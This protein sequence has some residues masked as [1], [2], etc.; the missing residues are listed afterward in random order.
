[1]LMGVIPREVAGHFLAGRRQKRVNVAAPAIDWVQSFRRFGDRILVLKDRFPV[2]G[3]G[4]PLAVVDARAFGLVLELVF[5]T[6]V[7]RNSRL[8]WAL[9]SR[10][11]N[12]TEG[13]VTRITWTGVA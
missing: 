3:Q 11:K 5:R 8:E 10:M 12:A 1:M 13:S 6:R 9:R 2:N 4:Q 7:T